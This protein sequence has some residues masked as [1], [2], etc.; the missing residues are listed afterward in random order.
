MTLNPDDYDLTPRD[1]RLAA[2]LRDGSKREMCA[3]RNI[4]IPEPSPSATLSDRMK[5]VVALPIGDLS[6]NFYDLEVQAMQ[7]G[8][9]RSWDI[10][11]SARTRRQ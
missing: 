4:T 10:V 5:M 3:R 2:V 9:E 1:V 7:I 6:P 11:S 8:W